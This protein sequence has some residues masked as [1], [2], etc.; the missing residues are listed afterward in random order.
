MNLRELISGALKRPMQ[1]AH[2]H[3]LLQAQLTQLVQLRAKVAVPAGMIGSFAL[4]LPLGKLGAQGVH[5][6]SFC[7]QVPVHRQAL[8]LLPA[9]YGADPAPKKPCYFFPGIKPLHAFRS[10][11][12]LPLKKRATAQI[13][14]GLVNFEAGFLRLVTPEYGSAIG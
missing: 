3:H 9:L 11:H 14:T 6:S 5:R 2:Q 10:T 7:V 12:L 4:L 1:F 13:L 8:G